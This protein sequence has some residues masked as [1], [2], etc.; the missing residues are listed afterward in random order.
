[1][2]MIYR[3]VTVFLFQ[4]SVALMFTDLNLKI[5]SVNVLHDVLYTVF[6]KCITVL[7]F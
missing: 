4:A 3:I 6:S 7:L 2:T 1:M 5:L